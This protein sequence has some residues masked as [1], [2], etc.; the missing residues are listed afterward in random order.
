MDDKL[1]ERQQL[2]AEV[3]SLDY[4]LSQLK[5]SAPSRKGIIERR[6][7][8]VRQLQAIKAVNHK[9]YNNDV[10]SDHAVLRWLERKH[11]IDIAK[12]KKLMLTEPLQE[13]IKT[14]G[15]FWADEDVVFVIEGKRVQTII[16]VNEL[17]EQ[18]A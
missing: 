5:R 2:V 15:R 12:L 17:R 6:E 8:L 9:Y 1:R 3:Q 14:G 11:G 13:A 16:P 7:V 18:A 10:I 4:Q